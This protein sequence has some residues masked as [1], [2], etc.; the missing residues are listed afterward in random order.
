MPA[1][2]KCS[3]FGVSVTVPITDGHL[4]LGT[5]QVLLAFHIH[6]KAKKTVYTQQQTERERGRIRKSQYFLLIVFCCLLLF[7]TGSL[8]M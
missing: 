2:I 6:N 8:V 7:E 1:H 3:L 5:W 4:N